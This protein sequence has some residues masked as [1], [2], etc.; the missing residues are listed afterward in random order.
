MLQ[1]QHRAKK[2]VKMGKIIQ[3]SI[4]KNYKMPYQNA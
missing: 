2:I 4:G 1:L 3:K